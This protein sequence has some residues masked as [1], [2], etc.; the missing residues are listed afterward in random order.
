MPGFSQYLNF[1]G[2]SFYAPQNEF[3][4]D[5]SDISD[6]KSCTRIS[7]SS[8]KSVITDILPM[9]ITEDK[10]DK[11]KKPKLEG[12]NMFIMLAKKA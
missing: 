2:I 6:L 9:C 7:D 1:N 3:D 4:Y 12:R 8:H 5:I 11:K 10:K